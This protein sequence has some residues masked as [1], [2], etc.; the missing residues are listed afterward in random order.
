MNQTSSTFLISLLVMAVGGCEAKNTRGS[1]QILTTPD[2]VIID[3]YVLDGNKLRVNQ[4]EFGGVG[5]NTTK[6]R[7]KRYISIQHEM[8]GDQPVKIRLR[9]RVGGLAIS[10]DESLDDVLIESVVSIQGPAD[11]SKNDRLAQVK[12]VV[13]PASDGWLEVTSKWP[14]G[15]STGNEE[16]VISVTVPR[17]DSIDL[18][19][20]NGSITA[21]SCS[22][23]VTAK[24]MNGNITA[25]NPGG[26]IDLQCSNGSINLT[27]PLNWSGTV[28]ARSDNGRINTQ[29]SSS[30]KINTDS[31]QDGRTDLQVGTTTTDPRT[32]TLRTKN[33]S[34]DI[35][36]G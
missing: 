34:I 9:N 25:M 3:N 12:L 30:A 26:D 6:E 17:L 19:T 32:A 15:E 2:G 14:G 8:N 29:S 31:Y 1:G 23:D 7:S 35:Q 24:T 13:T 11:Q 36:V 28:K 20:T 27:L 10:L 4:E 33:G 21:G 22:G 18:E 16:C 5:Q